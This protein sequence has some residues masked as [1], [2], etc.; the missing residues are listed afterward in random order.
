M[1]PTVAALRARADE[2]VERALAENQGALGVADRSRPRADAGDG[3]GDRQPAAARADPAPQAGGV[4]R[5]PPPHVHALRELFGL[6][7]AT[8]ALEGADAEVTELDSRRRARD[9]R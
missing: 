4:G 7:P 1:T 9:Q 2:I 3:P 8:D 6:D 5:R